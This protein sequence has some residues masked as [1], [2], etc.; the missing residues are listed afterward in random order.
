MQSVM[1]IQ[2]GGTIEQVYGSSGGLCRDC[3]HAFPKLFEMPGH[4]QHA[5]QTW[6]SKPIAGVARE[7]IAPDAAVAYAQLA[8]IVAEA[9]AYVV[10][11][12]DGMVT[13]SLRKAHR[14]VEAFSALPGVV[15]F[16]SDSPAS[17]EALDV[18]LCRNSDEPPEYFPPGWVVCQDQTGTAHPFHVMEVVSEGTVRELHGELIMFIGD[19]DAEPETIPDGW[20]V[21][22]NQTIAEARPFEVAEVV[23]RGAVRIWRGVVIVKRG[24]RQACDGEGESRITGN[25]LNTPISAILGYFG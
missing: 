16:V 5:T 22:M 12:E 18:R 25:R 19:P 17:G 13:S 2:C 23:T 1:C 10:S 15:S 21:G 8:P 6:V 4:R 11:E 14:I 24:D 7:R 9:W 20:A 3:G